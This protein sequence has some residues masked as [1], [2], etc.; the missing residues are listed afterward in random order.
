M[1]FFKRIAAI[2]LILLTVTTSFTAVAC[3]KDVP[4]SERVSSVKTDI[5]KGDYDGLTVTAELYYGEYPEI[6]DG[7]VGDKQTS[8]VF[9]VPLSEPDKS[10]SVTMNYDGKLFAENFIYDGVKNALVATIFPEGFDKKT[11]SA[12]ITLSSS[13]KEVTFSSIVKGDCLSYEKILSA[14]YERQKTFIE[15]FYDGDELNAEIILKISVVSEKIYWFVAV[16]GENGKGKAML[17]DGVTADVLAV[18]DVLS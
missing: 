5:F 8:L 18:K 6:R 2:F 11:F 9:T 14:L 4:L 17:F 1:K 7:K 16:W 10:Y 13:V 3:K 12:K 15:S